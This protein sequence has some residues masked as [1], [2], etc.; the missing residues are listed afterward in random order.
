[1]LGN[2]Y[3]AHDP[4][5]YDVHTMVVDPLLFYNAGTQSRF[6]IDWQSPSW[7]GFTLEANYSG[8]KDASTP[9]DEQAYGIQADYSNYGIEASLGYS[10]QQDGMFNGDKHEHTV[11][12]AALAYKW[13]G[14][15]FWIR[16]AVL[17]ESREVAI[18]MNVASTTLTSYTGTLNGDVDR[19]QDHYALNL[20]VGFGASTINAFY[21]KL[22]KMDVSY[23]NT[24]DGTSGTVNNTND[25]AYGIEYLYS[26]S[27][28]TSLGLGY[29]KMN[30]KNGANPAYF[31]IG[32]AHT[33]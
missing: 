20:G 14:D 25:S 17:W 1:M 30:D 22:S 18:D 2:E 10:K 9:G 15:G 11:L 33:F 24:A 12:S 7:G 5:I 29:S 27:S 3:T 26:L 19:D 21:S 16:P 4:D 6:G 13:E 23:A 31:G 28:R 8:N 32:I